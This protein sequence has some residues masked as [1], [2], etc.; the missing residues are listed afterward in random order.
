MASATARGR[1]R[2]LVPPSTLLK[3]ARRLSLGHDSH[4]CLS[5]LFRRRRR[6]LLRIARSAR[7]DRRALAGC[8]SGPVVPH[9]RYRARLLPGLRFRLEYSLRPDAPRLRPAIRQLAAFLADL[10]VLHGGAGGTVW[11]RR[12]DLHGKTVVDIGCG[13]GD[14]L[15]MLCEAGDNA[16]YGF[17][18]VIRRRAATERDRVRA[19]SGARSTTPRRIRAFRRTLSPRASSTNTFPTRR[20]PS[21]GAPLDPGPGP[22]RRLLRGAQHRLIVRQGSVWDIIY[23][24]CSYFGPESLT[25]SFAECG[26]RVLRVEETYGRQFLT[27]DARADRDRQTATRGRSRATST[28]LAGGDHRLSAMPRPRKARRVAGATR[29]VAAGKAGRSPPGAPAPRRSGFLNMLR[30][31]DVISRVVDINPFKQGR[32]LQELGSGSCRPRPLP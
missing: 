2:T 8:R 20:V 28:R 5:D 29:P 30:D 24:H 27:I 31:R 3:T 23:E 22:R 18:P 26:F 11:S 6:D 25:R 4:P 14:F 13:K 19:S 15:V 32:H 10:P 12:Y 16:G 21:D 1:T 9:G 7:A 17:D